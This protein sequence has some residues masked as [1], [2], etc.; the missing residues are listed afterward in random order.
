MSQPNNNQKMHVPW[1]NNVM[2]MMKVTIFSWK[3][4]QAAGKSYWLLF[5]CLLLEICASA[6][7]FDWA[8]WIALFVFVRSLYSI[9]NICIQI[10][11]ASQT[12]RID[13]KEIFTSSSAFFLSAAQFIQCIRSILMVMRKL[14][15][16][17]SK[18][19]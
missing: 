1:C 14:K 4:I 11:D 5:F 6:I 16:M 10:V 19:G 15:D 2:M 3:K 9:Y 8:K 12:Y 7:F 17:R 13:D 18:N